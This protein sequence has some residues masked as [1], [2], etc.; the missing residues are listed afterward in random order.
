MAILQYNKLGLYNLSIFTAIQLDSNKK[1]LGRI[2]RKIVQQQSFK[3][4]NFF[5]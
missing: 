2:L 5:P 4:L 3:G 1:S